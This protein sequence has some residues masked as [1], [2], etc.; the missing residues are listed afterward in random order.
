[1]NNNKIKDPKGKKVSKI[2]K[3]F[4]NINQSNLPSKQTN[5]KF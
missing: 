4:I 5:N 3:N 2:F 1:M